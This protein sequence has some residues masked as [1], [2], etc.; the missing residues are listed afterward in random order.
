MGADSPLRTGQSILERRLR[1]LAVYLPSPV[2][3]RNRAARKHQC[4]L[5]EGKV[6]LFSE[7]LVRFPATPNSRQNFRALR[8]PRGCKELF[9]VKNYNDVCALSKITL[10][11]SWLPGSWSG[12]PSTVC[13]TGNPSSSST[14][15][16]E[17]QRHHAELC[18][19]HPPSSKSDFAHN[20]RVN[21]FLATLFL[22]IVVT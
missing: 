20:Q 16:T 14:R 18:S 19:F 21:I 6:F 3:C 9:Q 2:S 8:E 1:I 5:G 4:C 7:F 15:D 17:M 22:L 10:F 12:L 11:T 13:E